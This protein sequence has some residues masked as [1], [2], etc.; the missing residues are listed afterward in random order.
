MATYTLSPFF[1]HR[2]G[3][4]RLAPEVLALLPARYTLSIIGTNDAFQVNERA[5]KAT[6]LQF[7]GGR[8]F[9]D[10]GTRFTLRE[11]RYVVQGFDCDDRALPQEEF[12]ELLATLC[13][14]SSLQQALDSPRAAQG[15]AANEPTPGFF[16][17]VLAAFGLRRI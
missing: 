4:G 2:I 16:D 6:L 5:T 11:D 12:L 17:Q 15:S 7:F 1:S 10:H 3:A 9:A 8:L 14:M 13:R